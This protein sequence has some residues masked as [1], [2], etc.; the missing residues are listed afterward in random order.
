MKI[1]GVFETIDRI[2]DEHS[3][4]E[5]NFGKEKKPHAQFGARIIP[6]C[7]HKDLKSL[8]SALY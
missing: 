8:F 6:L 1:S 3:S 2:E 7:P 5:Q 4:E